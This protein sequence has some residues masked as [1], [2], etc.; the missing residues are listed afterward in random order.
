MAAAGTGVP[1]VTKHPPK[2]LVPQVLARTGHE[3]SAGLY[4]QPLS[5]DNLTV[6]SRDSADR[7]PRT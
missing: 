6:Y 3:E 4:V 7:F 2:S 1:L 5:S